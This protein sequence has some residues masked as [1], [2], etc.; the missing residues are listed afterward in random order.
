[1]IT[2]LIPTY[3][4][5]SNIELIV[6]KINSLSLKENYKIF[7]IDDDSKDGSLSIFKKLKDRD[8]NV[9]FYIRKSVARDLTQS[10][11]HALKFI[12]NDVM[13]L[14]LRPLIKFNGK[15]RRPQAP[16]LR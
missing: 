5:F 14:K 6:N 1:M 7:F 13:V 16:L 3:N 2:F 8:K 15:Y 11:I 10:I 4:E 12:N 9:D